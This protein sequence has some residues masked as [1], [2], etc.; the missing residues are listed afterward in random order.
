MISDR[1]TGFDITYDHLLNYFAERKHVDDTYFSYP[2]N[3]GCIIGATSQVFYDSN[4]RPMCHGE[5]F[6]WAG[7]GRDIHN[8]T[9][10]PTAKELFESHIYEG[11]SFKER[12]SK[13]E[14]DIIDGWMRIEDF[15]RHV[16][17]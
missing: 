7:V 14:W 8:G 9:D 15:D 5:T 3:E 16:Q 4:L 10:Y 13:I 2:G 6:Y 17:S 12:W 11:K 1:R